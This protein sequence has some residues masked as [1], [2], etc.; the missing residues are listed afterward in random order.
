MLGFSLWSL[1]F[2]INGSRGLHDPPPAHRLHPAR[3]QRGGGGA[4]MRMLV[5]GGRDFDASTVF[6]YLER[7]IKGD[8][9][10]ALGCSVFSIDCLIHGGA[11]GA[12]EGAAR[13]GESEGIKVLSFP[14]DWKK[15]GKSAG[16]R[17]NARMLREGHPDV[18]IAFP[19]GRG[20]ANMVMLAEGEGVP[21]IKLTGPFEK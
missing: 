20:T 7:Y 6:N 1:F 11:R 18:V 15:H 16:P 3:R 10:E 17:R 8:I 13:W 4:I 21:V 2:A 14:A 12:D 9:H 5:C 19:G